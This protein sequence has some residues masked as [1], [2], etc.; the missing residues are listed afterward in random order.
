ML[1]CRCLRFPDDIRSDLSVNFTALK[2]TEVPQKSFRNKYI[3]NE[4]L[5]VCRACS[6]FMPCITFF[7][8]QM[9]MYPNQS[10]LCL[11]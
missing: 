6:L 2:L 8:H 7:G 4:H 10:A 9:F 1:Q 3:R 11:V 5:K